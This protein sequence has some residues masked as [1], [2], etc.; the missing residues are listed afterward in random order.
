MN[1]RTFAI[2]Q[3]MRPYLNGWLDDRLSAGLGSLEEQS[4]ILAVAC[5]HAVEDVVDC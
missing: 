3:L 2:C 1:A 5:S 4:V